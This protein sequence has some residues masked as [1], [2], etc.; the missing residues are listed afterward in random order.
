M[1]VTEGRGLVKGWKGR[2]QDGREGRDSVTGGKG[3]IQ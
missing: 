2:I 3:G 1:G